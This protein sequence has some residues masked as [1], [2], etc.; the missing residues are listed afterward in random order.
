MR[1]R[2][3]Y[4]YIVRE[5]INQPKDAMTKSCEVDLVTEWDQKVEKLLIDGISSKFPDHKRI[6]NTS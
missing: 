6:E 5:K 3:K 2:A 1:I 4:Q